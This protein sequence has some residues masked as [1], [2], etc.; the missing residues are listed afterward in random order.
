MTDAGGTDQQSSRF[1]RFVEAAQAK[2]SRA[3]WPT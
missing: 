1:G 2:V 3:Q